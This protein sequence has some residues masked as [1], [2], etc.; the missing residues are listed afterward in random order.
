MVQGKAINVDIIV[1]SA[2][3]Y[4]DAINRLKTSKEK[5]SGI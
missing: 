2:S 4:I 5:V 3:A 1:A